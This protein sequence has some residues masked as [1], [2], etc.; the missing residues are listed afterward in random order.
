MTRLWGRNLAA[1]VILLPLLLCRVGTCEEPPGKDL[2]L[3][4]VSQIDSTEQPYRIYV[5]SIYDGRRAMPLIFAL[6]GT[7]GTEATMF[8]AEH[9]LRGGIKQAAEKHG[10][11]LVS[12][13]GRGKTEYRGI[14][15]N[16]VFCVLEDVRRRYR[17]DEDRI[18]LTGHSMGAT[19]AAYLALHHPDVFAAAAPLAAAYSY[20]WLARNAKRVPF[21]WI[22]GANDEE[23]YHRGVAIGVERM[24]KFGAPVTLEIL[25]GE[26]HRGPVKDFD[27]VF[28]WLLKHKREAHP[29]E[30]VFEADTPLHGRAW[31]VSVD[32]MAQ[33]GRM[34][35]IQGQ[36]LDGNVA[37][38]TT[39]NVAEFRFLP[40]PKVF[41]TGQPI[42][43]IVDGT[44]AFTGS[45]PS[46]QELRLAGGPPNWK[47]EV[48]ECR[49]FSSTAYRGHPVAVA[50]E[51]LDMVGVE[52]RLANWITDA[53]RY[54]TG[55][56]IAIYNARHYRGLPIPKGTVDIVD[57]I[58]CSRPFNQSLVT[59][60][61]TGQDLLEILED[62]LPDP[63]RDPDMASD[64][65]GAGFLIQLSGAR[66]AFNL[67]RAAGR[68]IVD[69]D[70]QPNRLYKVV[71][72]GQV[73]ARETIRLAGRFKNFDYKDTETSFTLALYGYAAESGRIETRIEGRVREAKDAPAAALRMTNLPSSGADGGREGKTIVEQGDHIR[74]RQEAVWLIENMLLG[75]WCDMGHLT[76]ALWKIPSQVTCRGAGAGFRIGK[77]RANGNSIAQSP[78]V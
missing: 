67:S 30:I 70:L 4:Y 71:M 27:R 48:R 39:T 58:Q 11:L 62:N 54:A 66:Y 46:G 25:P 75:L 36:A 31:W 52:K 49:S 74:P 77:G 3:A 65:P 10:V 72:E 8:E 23:F 53:M 41:D 9:Y 33:P 14:G 22:G 44:P 37:R 57:L 26:G 29:R 43:V 63:R 6:H 1:G 73:V 18:Y 68:R 12:P 17:V 61:L 15:E 5:P 24:R 64:G 51:A 16:D 34:A 19:G 59:V 69:S 40:D 21:L 7:S 13:L 20:P 32:A 35:L 60:E 28:S 2:R 78:E 47:A 76:K 38:I 55:A 56:D 42:R 45:I 50:P